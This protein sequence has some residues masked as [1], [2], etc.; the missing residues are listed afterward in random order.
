MGRAKRSGRWRRW[1]GRGRYSTG[2]LEDE[3]GC[4]GGFKTTGEEVMDH[5]D[6][7]SSGSS[8]LGSPTPSI[9][10]DDENEHTSLLS[11]QRSRGISSP[12]ITLSSRLRAFL[13]YQPQ[14]APYINKALPQNQTTLSILSLLL[15]NFFYT[16]YHIAFDSFSASILGDRASLIFATNLPLL[17]ILSAKTQP[18]NLLTGTSYESLNI[19]HRRLG[20]LLIFEALLHGICMFIMW[21]SLLKPYSGWSLWDFLSNQCIY[22]GIMALVT[23]K[24]LYITSLA[25]FRQR[26]YEL[27]L[28]THVV[29]QAAALLILY[30]HHRG[31]RKYVGWALSIFVV[32]RL[33]YRL[34]VKSTWAEVRLPHLFPLQCHQ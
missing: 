9:K 25:S 11:H 8:T 14:S 32:D 22:L 4:N 28:G 30:F 20:G 5:D 15:L 16:F 29:L 26:W 34:C 24:C 7:G 10:L 31:S 13:I 2:F 23:Y 27:F 19:L 33:V 18:L 3:D 6:V 1:R 21:Y 12:H 17:Y